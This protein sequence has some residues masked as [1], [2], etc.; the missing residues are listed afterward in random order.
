LEAEVTRLKQANEQQSQR[1]QQLDR[2]L[3]ILQTRP[4][5]N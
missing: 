5:V 2:T 3:K 4:G 1:I